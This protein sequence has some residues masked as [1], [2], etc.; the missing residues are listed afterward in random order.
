MIPEWVDFAASA[1]AKKARGVHALALPADQLRREMA[2]SRLRLLSRSSGFLDLDHLAATVGSAARTDVMRPLH[3]TAVAAAHDRRC[4][5]EVVAAAVALPVPADLLLWKCAHVI[6]PCLDTGEHAWC[7]VVV[8]LC[9]LLLAV[10]RVVGIVIKERCEGAKSAPLLLRFIIAP[11]NHWRA[12]AFFAANRR[13]RDRQHEILAK[14]LGKV[15]LVVLIN[16]EC[17]FVSRVFL[18]VAFELSMIRKVRAAANIVELPELLAERR[19][20]PKVE[21]RQTAN[22][23][24]FDVRPQLAVG[25]DVMPEPGQPDPSIDVPGDQVVIQR[26]RIEI[27]VNGPGAADVFLEQCRDIEPG[28]VPEMDFLDIACHHDF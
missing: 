9:E 7:P 26:E 3:A 4:G 14:R 15:K 28:L 16:D 18:I 27:D 12:G 13:H 23:L 21:H 8:P 22:A 24:Q 19:L 2:L 6:S 17:V 20:C 25:Q 10:A 11:L 5:E 1:D